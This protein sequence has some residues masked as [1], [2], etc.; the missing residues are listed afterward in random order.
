MHEEAFADELFQQGRSAACLHVW[1]RQ[2]RMV[3]RKNQKENAWQNG[4]SRA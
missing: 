2:I 4:G 3:N 1:K